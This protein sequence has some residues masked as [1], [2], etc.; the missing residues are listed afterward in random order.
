MMSPAHLKNYLACF[1]LLCVFS[2]QVFSEPVTNILSN[3]DPGNRVD[4]VILGDGYTSVQ[5]SSYAND[6][7]TFVTSRFFND[8]PFRDYIN[9]FNVHRIDV[10]SKESGADHQEDS[11]YKDT[12]LGAFYNCSG[13]ERLIC[14]DTNAITTVL[15]NSVNSS[16]QDI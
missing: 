13:I 2:V 15:N 10:I 3:G 5:M 4:I 12:A 9:Y 14:T 7:N 8:Q 11:V 1:S 16:Q 6:V